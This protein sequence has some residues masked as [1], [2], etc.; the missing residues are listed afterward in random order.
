M[1]S[2]ARASS[3]PQN[4][5]RISSRYPTDIV[6]LDEGELE[7]LADVGAQANFR[8]A[9]DPELLRTFKKAVCRGLPVVK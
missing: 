3:A 8:R 6:R 1:I 7:L 2:V 4:G 5:K 9:D